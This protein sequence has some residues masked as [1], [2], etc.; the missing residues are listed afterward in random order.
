MTDIEAL[1]L[2]PGDRVEAQ[3]DG[4]W[5]LCV[6]ETVEMRY[7]QHP[8]LVFYRYRRIGKTRRGHRFPLNQVWH[9]ESVLVRRVPHHDPVTANVFADFLEDHGEVI[10]ANLLRKTFPLADGKSLGDCS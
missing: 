7:M 2:K 9:G 8:P 5:R 1:A 4:V 6:I 3:L 10:A